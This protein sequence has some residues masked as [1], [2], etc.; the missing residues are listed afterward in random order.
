MNEKA[1][2][3][4]A[5]AIFMV[6]G[7]GFVVEKLA[8]MQEHGIRVYSANVSTLQSLASETD[9]SVALEWFRYRL[10]NCIFDLRLPEAVWRELGRSLGSGA[11]H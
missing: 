11:R 8:A 6:Y 1:N 4:T 5:E 3:N 2:I 10:C 9:L 7:L